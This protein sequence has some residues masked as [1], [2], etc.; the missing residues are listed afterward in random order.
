MRRSRSW[1]RRRRLHEQPP[2]ARVGGHRGD[3]SPRR[4]PAVQPRVVMRSWGGSRERRWGAGT[5][6]Q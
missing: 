2:S 5:G 6:E 3:S 1:T 4:P